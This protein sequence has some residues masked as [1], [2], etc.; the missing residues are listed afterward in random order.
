MP[1]PPDI[2]QASPEETGAAMIPSNRGARQSENSERE[3]RS[4]A[5]EGLHE[6][7]LRLGGHPP[8]SGAKQPPFRP[9]V[10]LKGPRKAAKSH[11]SWPKPP[12]PSAS[13]PRAAIKKILLRHRTG[14]ARLHPCRVKPVDRF[15]SGRCGCRRR[16]LRSC[17]VFDW[18]ARSMAEN[19]SRSCVPRESWP[20]PTRRDGAAPRTR[21]RTT[22][23]TPDRHS[24]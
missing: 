15:D 8:D 4:A 7:A 5:G 10:G 14:T 6:G 11:F 24:G 12:D 3:A 20:M 21:P 22:A 19:R 1:L 18:F 17:L 9:A 13:R 2:V 23:G 16:P